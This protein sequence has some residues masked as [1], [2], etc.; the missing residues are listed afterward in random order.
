MLVWVKSLLKKKN[1][2]FFYFYPTLYFFFLSLRSKLEISQTRN[3]GMQSINLFNPE[4][5]TPPSRVQAK[6]GP[7][8]TQS[9]PVR[10]AKHTT[11]SHPFPPSPTLRVVCFAYLTGWERVVC[12]GLQS[13]PEAYLTWEGMQMM[14]ILQL[15]SGIRLSLF[16]NKEIN[17]LFRKPIYC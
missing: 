12:L 1:S 13:K 11:L 9:H 16:K 8:T 5:L 2:F 14:P 4:P 17:L 15:C 3:L 7:G 10:Y 6:L